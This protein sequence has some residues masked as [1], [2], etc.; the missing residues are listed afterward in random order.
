[1]G[2]ASELVLSK[3]GPSNVLCFSEIVRGAYPDLKS[4]NRKFFQASGRPPFQ[5]RDGSCAAAKVS[6]MRMPSS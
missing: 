5:T 2:C 4:P 3:S 6:Q 1:M